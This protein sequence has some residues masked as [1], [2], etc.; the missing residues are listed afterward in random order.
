MQPGAMNAKL[1]CWLLSSLVCSVC[2]AGQ[3]VIV[4]LSFHVLFDGRRRAKVC[5]FGLLPGARSADWRVRLGSRNCPDFEKL[6][7]EMVEA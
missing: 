6:K 5:L 3:A 7:V 2:I 4:F 1:S